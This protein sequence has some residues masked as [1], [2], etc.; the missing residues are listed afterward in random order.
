MRKMKRDEKDKEKIKDATM[1]RDS[2]PWI[3]RKY[4]NNRE[5]LIR[6]GNKKE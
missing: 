3:R 4:E 6:K 5:F 1:E 2:P